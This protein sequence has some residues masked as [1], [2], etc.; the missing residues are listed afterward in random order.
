MSLQE[1]LFPTKALRAIRKIS[2]T[3]TVD[4]LFL[5]PPKNLCELCG[6]V[7]EPVSLKGTKRTKK[8]F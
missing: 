6:F 4:F 3:E 2:K 8:K 7:G 1:N 5:N